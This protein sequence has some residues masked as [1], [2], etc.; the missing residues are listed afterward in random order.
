MPYIASHLRAL[1]DEYID[2]IIGAIKARPEDER[3]GMS[4][5]AVFRILVGLA[6]PFNYS[7]LRGYVGDLICCLLEFYRRRIA[8]YED[9]AIRRNGDIT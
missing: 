7:V 1:V 4:N 2:E 6:T 8:P 5:Y 3:G 9:D